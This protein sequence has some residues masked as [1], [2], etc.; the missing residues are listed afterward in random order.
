M[1]NNIFSEIKNATKSFL[2]SVIS[3]P[4]WCRKQIHHLKNDLDNLRFKLKDITNSNM[5]LGIFHLKRGNYKDAIF[6]FKL[7][8]KYLDPGNKI[9][10][11]WL[12]WVYLVRED[13][14]N[15][16]ICLT[17]AENEDKTHLLSFIKA[18][19]K[20][21]S[22]PPEIHA[23][24]RDIK[25]L[26]FIDKVTGNEENIPK[27]LVIELNKVMKGL[28]PEYQVLELGSNVGLL[29]YEIRKRMPGTF[30]LTP[31]EISAEMINLQ[32]IIFP[33]QYLYDKVLQ[34]PVNEYLKKAEQ[35]YDIV[36]S[37]NGFAFASDL[38]ETFHNVFSLLNQGGYFAFTVRSSEDSGLSGKLLEFV[39]KEAYVSAVLQETGF[40]VLAS[41]K[42]SLAMQGNYTIFICVK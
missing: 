36:F 28:P 3:F 15:A 10:N 26:D 21:Q 16:I 2:V 17:K 40:K 12:G 41:K 34:T 30:Q 42:F 1:G 20:M 4:K 19:D 39:Y 38:K 6:R 11:Y 14:K 32:P 35:K 23:I 9:A 7:I 24:H 33:D 5:E 37:L 29:G 31:T 18:I 8:D 13:Y 25:A 27:S 22:V